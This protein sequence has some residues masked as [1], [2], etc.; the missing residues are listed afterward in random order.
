[1]SRIV[2]VPCV[3]EQDGDGA[4]WS[5]SAHLRADVAAFGEGATREEAIADL[6]AGLELLFEEVG[7]PDFL[8]VTVG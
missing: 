5:A 8:E 6:R 3:I 7:T 1:M 2:H 4:G